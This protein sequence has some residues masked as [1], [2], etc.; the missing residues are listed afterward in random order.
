MLINVKPVSPSMSFLCANENFNTYINVG[1]HGSLGDG[2]SACPHFYALP[3]QRRATWLE[4]TGFLLH[5]WTRACKRIP[6]V[7]FIKSKTP[8]VILGFRLHHKISAP[9]KCTKRELMAYLIFTMG[10]YDAVVN[11]SG[12]F[13]YRVI[14]YKNH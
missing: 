3:P 11:W 1:M 12:C 2:E 4:K 7:R 13:Q 14:G 10:K 5:H 6:T 9:S 8:R